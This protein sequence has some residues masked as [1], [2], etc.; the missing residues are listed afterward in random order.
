MISGAGDMVV[1]RVMLGYN[2][3]AFPYETIFQLNPLSL[4]GKF[5]RNDVESILMRFA[6]KKSY[7][8]ID[9]LEPAHIDQITKSYSQNAWIFVSMNSRY[10]L[11]NYRKIPLDKSTYAMNYNEVLANVFDTILK[12]DHPK[13]PSV[14]VNYLWTSINLFTFL[15]IALHW[16]IKKLIIA[17][18]LQIFFIVAAPLLVFGATSWQLDTSRPFLTLFLLQYLTIPY[19]F[20]KFARQNDLELAKTREEKN[21]AINKAKVIAKSAKAD[22]GFR[23][24]TQVAHDIKSPIMALETV[25]MLARKEMKPETLQL[26]EKSITRINNIADSL[27]KKF[28]SGSFETINEAG[29]TDIVLTLKNLIHTYKNMYPEIKILTKT[30]S[31][32]VLIPINE[33]EIER[34]LT[35]VINNSIEAMSFKGEIHISVH[36]NDDY[37]QILIQDSGRGIPEEL[38]S[39]IF[40]HGFTFDKETGSGIGL[41][42]T[43][44]AL[45]KSGG[46]IVLETSKPGITIFKLIL[47]K[48]N[49]ADLK[50][51]TSSN[52]ILIEDVLET[53]E[54]WKKILNESNVKVIAFNSYRD[55][56][57]C[58]EQQNFNPF[59]NQKYTLITDLIFDGEEETGFEAIQ[60]CQ[61]QSSKFLFNAYLCTSL[62]SNPEIQ[63]IAKDFGVKIFGKKD[64]DKI[65]VEAETST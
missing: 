13:I 20:I 2:N 47:A 8:S 44:D 46:D 1:R 63:S 38:Q 35:N 30:S 28:K 58:M 12:Q 16:P 27:L 17:S 3:K 29:S 34:A 23:I 62:S 40:E 25:K 51:K 61:S 52:V 31:Q 22:L 32:K 64:L 4:N 42:Q 57:S 24:A 50:I 5:M 21:K 9:I 56:L 26:L 37:A 48:S 41:S 33:V 65:K 6:N 10:D 59:E 49:S 45:T 14:A 53:A 36:D 39:K 19:V 55:F 15:L 43:K 7:V 11:F 18:F 54:L 60:L